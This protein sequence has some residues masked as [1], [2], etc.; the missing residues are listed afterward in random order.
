MN[1]TLFSIVTIFLIVF[2]SIIST[3]PVEEINS[4]KKLSNITANSV[5]NSST[6]CLYGFENVNGTCKEIF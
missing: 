6:E 4:N 1:R 2:I 3:W 5:S